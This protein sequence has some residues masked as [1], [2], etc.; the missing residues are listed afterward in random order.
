MK[1]SFPGGYVFS[2]AILLSLALPFVGRALAGE[3][4]EGTTGSTPT[5]DAIGESSSIVSSWFNGLS[6]GDQ[7]KFLDEAARE[8]LV[9]A[10]GKPFTPRQFA[11]LSDFVDD[12]LTRQ[13]LTADDKH[14]VLQR[15]QQRAG[16]DTP[17]NAGPSD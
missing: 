1:I 10:N 3:T 9:A 8:G 16:I 5:K 14:N 6:P 17:A 4:G 2:A 7:R 15:M 11:A 12:D 13:G